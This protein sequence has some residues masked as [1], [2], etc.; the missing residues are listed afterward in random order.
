MDKIIYKKLYNFLSPSN[1]EVK[2]DLI[3]GFGHFDLRIAKQCA[4]LFNKNL[5]PKI[6]FTGGIGAGSGDFKNPEAEEFQNY[7]VNNHPGINS[8]DIL[9]EKESTN[10]GENIRNSI[11]ILKNNELLDSIRRIILVATPS[12]Q[13]RVNLTVKKFLPHIELVNLPPASSFELDL[14]THN[15]KGFDFYDLLFGEFNRIKSYPKLGYS[16]SIKIPQELETL[17]KTD[18]TT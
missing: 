11:N 5:A 1:K 2:A 15:E 17:Y 9:I 3:M 12:R 18:T 8:N 10:T 14:K 16:C 4:S 13:L 6:L 7:L